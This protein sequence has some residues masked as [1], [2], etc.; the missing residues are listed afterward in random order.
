MALLWLEKVKW[1]NFFFAKRAFHIQIVREKATNKYQK[2]KSVELGDQLHYHHIIIGGKW[3]KMNK[4]AKIVEEG[5]IVKEVKRSDVLPVA[6]FKKMF[7]QT[8][9]R[10]LKRKA[11][12]GQM[13]S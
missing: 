1:S 13:H 3:M 2:Y 12:F 7:V 9:L 11:Y 6:M 5:K 8:F 4:D 10:K